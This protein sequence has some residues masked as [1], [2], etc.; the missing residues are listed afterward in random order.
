MKAEKLYDI[1]GTIFLEMLRDL[2]LQG[3]NNMI[4]DFQE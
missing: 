3:D 1:E 4:V 2:S